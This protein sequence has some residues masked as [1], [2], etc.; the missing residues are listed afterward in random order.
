[1]TR[2]KAIEIL[3]KR[4]RCCKVIAEHANEAVKADELQEVEAI[5]LAI[6]ALRG[7][8]REQVERMFRGCAD[9]QRKTCVSCRLF[10]RVPERCIDCNNQDKWSPWNFC[11]VCGKPLTNEAVDMMLERWKEAVDGE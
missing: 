11:P 3:R 9:C 4:Q 2:E 1:M 5:D 7:P 6:A 10:G 8:T